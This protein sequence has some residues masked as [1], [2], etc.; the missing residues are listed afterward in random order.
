M[1]WV[2]EALWNMGFP[3]LATLGHD[4]PFLLGYTKW[5]VKKK[6]K[7]MLLHEDSE[8]NDMGWGNDSSVKNNWK[9]SSGEKQAKGKRLK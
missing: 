4:F 2:G 8:S 1:L 9:Y 6:K 7:K 3:T 5:D